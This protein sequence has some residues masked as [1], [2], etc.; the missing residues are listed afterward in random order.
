M[1]DSSQVSF[2][3][4]EESRFAPTF[5]TRSLKLWDD[6]PVV[7]RLDIVLNL[8]PGHLDVGQD[9]GDHQQ[10]HQDGAAIADLVGGE[11]LEIGPGGEDLGC[12]AGSAFGHDVDDSEELE[13]LDRSEQHD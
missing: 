8:E 11:G 6:T 5:R 3:A 2:R 10:Y 7:C 4:G 1:S 9:K 12:V 13:T